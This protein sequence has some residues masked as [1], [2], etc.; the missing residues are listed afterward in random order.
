[1]PLTTCISYPPFVLHKAAAVFLYLVS[2]QAI[3]T[4]HNEILTSLIII[5][6]SIS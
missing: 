3:S 5:P 1:M 6:L 4:Q 2:A